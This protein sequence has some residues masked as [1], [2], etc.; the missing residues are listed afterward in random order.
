MPQYSLRRD[1]EPKWVSEYIAAHYG[2]YPVRPRC[3][4][5][6]IPEEVKKLYGQAKGISFYRPW[7]PEVDAIVVMPSALLL[8]EAK[9]FKYMDGLSKLPVYKSLIPTTPEL[10]EYKDF[11]VVMR[12][13]IPVHIAWVE[14]AGAA[15]GVEVHVWST[16]EI[17]KAWNERDKYWSKDAQFIRE[18]RKKAMR[19][20]GFE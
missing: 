1:L 13:L 18:Q 2:Q 3:P 16:P 8:L 20:L 7:R 11:N 5:G 6:P 12:L 10:Q 9:I 4:L 17:D 14:A 15:S 19:D